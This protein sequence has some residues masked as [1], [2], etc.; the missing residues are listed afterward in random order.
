V[1]VVVVVRVAA[2]AVVVEDGD[3]AEC[4]AFNLQTQRLVLSKHSEI[5]PYTGQLV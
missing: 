1:G 3:I 4:E 5:I 2:A